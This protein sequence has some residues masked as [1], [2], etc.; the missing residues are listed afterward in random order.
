MDSDSIAP[1]YFFWRRAFF[2]PLSFFSS[3][4]FILFRPSSTCPWPVFTAK[5]SSSPPPPP[6][7]RVPSV[8]L[9]CLHWFSK[10]GFLL[11]ITA[12]H[13]GASFFFFV[14]RLVAPLSPLFFFYLFLFSLTSL[15]LVSPY[16][17]SPKVD[18]DRFFFD[19]LSRN[20]SLPSVAVFATCFSPR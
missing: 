13:V 12:E 3:P 17:F 18:L 1:S 19:F 8:P 9:S 5:F 16:V 15:Q 20:G 11:S 6:K 7:S 2:A 4:L 10:K 14:F